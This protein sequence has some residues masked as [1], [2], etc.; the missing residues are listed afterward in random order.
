MQVIAYPI[1]HVKF[2][3]IPENVFVINEKTG[4]TFPEVKIKRC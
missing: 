4:D 2:D 1:I 3:K